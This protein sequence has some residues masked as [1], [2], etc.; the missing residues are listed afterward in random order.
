MAIC[1]HFSIDF[2]VY[3]P[4][5]NLCSLKEAAIVAGEE[6]AWPESGQPHTT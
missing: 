4:C 2:D 5:W 6:R 3:V 1:G